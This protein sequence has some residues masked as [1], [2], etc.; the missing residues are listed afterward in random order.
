MPASVESA[1]VPDGGSQLSV[2]MPVYNEEGTLNT[3]VR[4]VRDV[5]PEAEL[6]VVDDGSTDGSPGIIEDLRR[7]GLVDRVH[8]HG[9]NRGKG[10]ALNTG[11]ASTTRAL[12][13]VQDAD[14]EYDPEDYG[15]LLEPILNGSAD[16]VYGSRFYGSNPRRVIYF[17]HYAGNRLLTLFSN[18][19]TNLTLTDMETCYKCFRREVVEGLT[20]E[21]R[22]F[23]VEPEVTAKVAHAGWRISEVGISYAGRSFED[24][25]KIT[26]RDGVSALRCIVKYGLFRSKSR[27]NPK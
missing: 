18:V 7:Q 6:V 25:K 9:R 20:I 21:E 15:K 23:G 11:L 3:I 27:R 19:V 14:L 8:S 10:A 17:W 1:S 4:K 22:G 13:V 2:V 26:W 5:V 12:V 16:V 24:G